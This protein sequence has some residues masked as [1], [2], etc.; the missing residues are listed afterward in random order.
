MTLSSDSLA[1]FLEE[2][3]PQ[4]LAFIQRSLGPALRSKVEPDDIVQEVTVSALSSPEAFAVDG[5]DP[6]KLLCQLAE[7]RIIDAHRRHFSA[8]KRDA[9]RET[10]LNSAPAGAPDLSSFESLLVASITSPSAAFSRHQKEFRLQQALGDLTE[11]QRVIIRWRY[12]D[13]LATR[14]IAERLSKSD[15][16]IRVLLSRTI[17]ELQATLADA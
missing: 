1:A 4:L 14:D 10:S 6:F 2:H 9:G 12:V 15:G 8:Q 5:R 16:A 3:R 11:E 17:N 7:Q 13:G